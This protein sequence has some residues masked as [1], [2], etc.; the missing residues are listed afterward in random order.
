[1][2]KR[3]LVLAFLFLIILTVSAPWATSQQEGEVPAY[4]AGPP[5]KGTKLPPILTKDQ[6]WGDNAQFSYQTRAYELAAKIPAVLHQQ[7][8]YC[9]CDRMGHNSLHSCFENAHGARCDICLKELYYSYAQYRKGRTAT[10]IR[11]GIIAGEW[12]KVDLETAATVT[13]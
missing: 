6:L 13:E 5:P 12:R 4:N 10:Q 2:L 3:G 11:K 7:P 9:Y 1:M 8:C